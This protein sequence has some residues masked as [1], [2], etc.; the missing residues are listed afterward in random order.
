MKGLALN[1][2]WKW[3]W[4]LGL[5][6]GS[7]PPKSPPLQL[8]RLTSSKINPAAAHRTINIDDLRLAAAQQETGSRTHN[9]LSRDRRGPQTCIVADL[10]AP[11]SSS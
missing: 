1:G 11:C 7:I 10:R 5:V 3:L 4:R 2:Y 6:Y 8:P 9:T